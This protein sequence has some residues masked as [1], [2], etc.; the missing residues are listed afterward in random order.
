MLTARQVSEQTFGTGLRGYDRNEVDECLARVAESLTAWEGGK[1]G[2]ETSLDVQQVTFAI[3]VHG[4]EID[5][6][7]DF[8]DQ[9]VAALRT[10]ERKASHQGQ[11]LPPS[12]H[13]DAPNNPVTKA[14]FPR[15]RTITPN[16]RSQ[17]A[18]T[19][20][21]DRESQ[22]APTPPVEMRPPSP[23]AEPHAA[24]LTVTHADSTGRTVTVLLDDQP[25]G[26]LKP[27][28]TKH[29]HITAGTHWVAVKTRKRASNV[30]VIE[31]R[32]GDQVTLTCGHLASGQLESLGQTIEGISL[33]R[34][35]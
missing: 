31:P 27:G 14:T 9:V 3:A 11:P 32:E 5:V 17:E 2:S 4:Y 12:P 30:Q 18:G 10:H 26:K 34:A 7:D 22:P 6:V 21:Q 33:Q 29:F 24:K 23:P 19:P 16:S 13:A 25:I 28:T 35:E 8:L 1:P 15:K 20:T